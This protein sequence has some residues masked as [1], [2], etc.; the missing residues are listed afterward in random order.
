M[1]SAKKY[2]AWVFYPAHI[3]WPQCGI[4]LAWNLKNLG[5]NV[6]FEDKNSRIFLWNSALDL[7]ECV[8]LD[9]LL[10]LVLLWNVTYF[11]ILTDTINELFEDK[12][13]V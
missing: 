11:N 5:L 4:Y 8:T 12:T 1:F 10:I 6:G 2:L 9:R 7:Q 13:D 3:I